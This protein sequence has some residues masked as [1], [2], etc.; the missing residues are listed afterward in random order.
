MG[1]WDEF[2]A[3]LRIAFETETELGTITNKF[4]AK[5]SI[6][7]KKNDTFDEIAALKLTQQNEIFEY[8][9]ENMQLLIVALRLRK[10]EEKNE[11]AENKN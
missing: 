8:I 5:F 9:R 10:D 3:K 1:I 7:L 11:K 2:T 4:C 6:N